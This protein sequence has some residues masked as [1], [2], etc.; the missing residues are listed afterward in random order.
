MPGDARDYKITIKLMSLP[1]L[2]SKNKLDKNGLYIYNKFGERHPQ[3][4]FYFVGS[5]FFLF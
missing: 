5:I 2:G 3:D 4:K 1:L